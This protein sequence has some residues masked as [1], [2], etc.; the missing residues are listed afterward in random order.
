MSIACLL[1]CL[2]AAAPPVRATPVGYWLLRCS[3]GTSQSGRQPFSGRVSSRV[4]ARCTL[5][6]EVTEGL[7]LE[8]ASEPTAAS[9]EWGEEAAELGAD[10]W[11]QHSLVVTEHPRR[12]ATQWNQ[13]STCDD[14]SEAFSSLT[15]SNPEWGADCQLNLLHSSVLFGA[16]HEGGLAAA[17]NA[18]V[19]EWS[20]ASFE[21]ALLYGWSLWNPPIEEDARLFELCPATCAIVGVLK[22]GCHVDP[23]PLPPPAPPSAPGAINAQELRTALA[24]PLGNRFYLQPGTVLHT[25]GTPFELR[26][27]N[28]TIW[29]DGEGAVLDGDH[30]SSILSVVLGGRLRLESITLR[31]GE[32]YLGGGLITVRSSTVEL[33]SCSLTNGSAYYGGAALVAGGSLLM[34]HCKVSDVQAWWGGTFAVSGSSFLSAYQSAFTRSSSQ[35]HGGWLLQSGGSV[36]LT[37]GSSITETAARWH[38][39]VVSEAVGLFSMSDGCLV[40]NV[41][42]GGYGG[43]LTSSTG[44]VRISNG[45]QL[46]N[47]YGPR[48]G[49]AFA[50]SGTI[51]IEGSTASNITS[52]QLGALFILGASVLVTNS[53]FIRTTCPGD[54]GALHL[55]FG[56]V[57]FLDT[58]IASASAI[59]GGAIHMLAGSVNITRSTIVNSS[60]STTGGFAQIDGGTLLVTKQSLISNSRSREPGGGI[61][62]NAGIVTLTDGTVMRNSTTLQVGGAIW[63]GSGVLRL[64]NGSKIH[65]STA[66][67]DGGAIRQI[68]GSVYIYNQTSFTDSVAYQNGGFYSI[69]SGSLTMYDNCTV[70]TSTALN[71]GGAFDISSGAVYLTDTVIE[72]S[73]GLRGGC[74]LRISENLF[75]PPLF[76]LTFVQL[77]QNDCDELFIADGSFLQ[78]VFRQ[79]SLS[80]PS[81]CKTS[82][83]RFT[84]GAD[85]QRCGD[86]YVDSIAQQ[87]ASVCSSETEG[88]CTQSPVGET[89]ISSLTCRCVSPEYPNLNVGDER[90]APYLQGGCNQPV[91]LVGIR[92]VS[93]TVAVALRKT[94]STESL[95]NV[96]LQLRGNDDSGALSVWTV[97]NLAALEMRSP[98]LRFPVSSGEISFGQREV[99]LP[100]VL[101]TVG[102]RERAAS[103]EESVAVQVLSLHPG[104]TRTQVF[105]VSLTVEATTSFAVWGAVPPEEQCPHPTLAA[106]RWF[107]PGA[108][109]S[110]NSVPLAFTAI[111]YII[112]FTACDSDRLPVQ[113]QVPS[114]SDPRQFSVLLEGSPVSI[115]YAGE[116]RYSL[117]LSRRFHG[118]A[119]L[120]LLLGGVSLSSIV[121]QGHCGEGFVESPGSECGCPPNTEPV[122]DRC[123]LCRDGQHKPEPGNQSCVDE[124][125]DLLPYLL[126]GSGLLLLLC[127]FY[128]YRSYHSR[129]RRE[130]DL[131]LERDFMAITSHEVRNPLNGTV[132]WLRFL[133]ESQEEMSSEQRDMLGSAVQCTNLALRFLSS[134][135]AMYKLQAKALEPTPVRTRLDDVTREVVA[136]VRP[137]MREEVRLE[138]QTDDLKHLRD[139]ICDPSL[140]E[141]VLLNLCQNA[142]R[143]TTSGSVSVIATV[144]RAAQ[145]FEVVPQRKRSTPPT[146][147]STSEKSHSSTA[148]RS[149]IRLR[150]VERARPTEPDDMVFVTFTVQDTGPGISSFKGGDIFSRY[151]STGGVGIGL[152]LSKMIVNELGS[153]LEVISPW[154]STGAPGTSFKFTLALRF[155]RDGVD[156]DHSKCAV[157][158][159]LKSASPVRSMDDDK[160]AGPTPSLAVSSHE[161]NGYS[162]FGVNV[163][164][165]DDMKVNRKLLRKVFEGTFGCHVTEAATAEEVLEII[166]VQR[167]SFELILID[168]QFETNKMT[169]SQAVAELRKDTSISPVIISCSGNELR[170]PDRFDGVDGV[171]SK[172]YPDWRDGSLQVQLERAFERRRL[173]R[174]SVL[175]T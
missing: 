142:A 30:L 156:V 124:P 148:N 140:L 34:V 132:G 23:P 56:E 2:A 29:S 172:P 25:E 141:H 109:T 71:H 9:E 175:S 50:W 38:G 116:G 108:N 154:S 157:V 170:M 159:P 86:R 70:S 79:I 84:N 67:I 63:I 16:F 59:K 134:L 98:W 165:A 68:G 44:H 4:G 94:N 58:H 55:V 160:Q 24:T 136:V 61:N 82:I 32:S 102:L 10:L 155:A 113:H 149:K 166:L 60:A 14:T 162:F 135:S 168:E 40:A 49:L 53:S 150:S 18:T 87:E 19:R 106:S 137:Q 163:L 169:G 145:G 96:T 33:I 21:V 99:L 138:V 28:M 112:Y 89:S 81:G 52:A 147:S 39:G 72:D 3:D 158:P 121:L 48:G 105:H 123:V 83:T 46:V 100:V 35:L 69:R 47:V 151:M 95:V 171:W 31:N 127:I 1:L 57:T 120:A 161:D 66:T 101:S 104:A 36:L 17:C 173:A 65:Y 54:G 131:E 122:D 118:H 15:A 167:K 129:K 85:F 107:P 92:V 110:Q 75:A 27:G 152:H 42:C 146:V 62:I 51:L 6:F 119:N 80:R 76:H 45:C 73:H 5:E 130:R 22:E 133:Q 139:V 128:A 111:P 143:F 43:V 114:T 7:Q 77:R 12:L 11:P 20:D 78:M 97:Q 164:I 174:S 91:R 115:Q 117:R 41:S 90:M 26:G 93:E 126:G 125:V 64:C 8:L 74:I 88:A 103:Y 37:D 144:A 13:S 153:E